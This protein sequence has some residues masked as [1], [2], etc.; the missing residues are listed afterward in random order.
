[1]LTADSVQTANDS[2]KVQ[3]LCNE[4]TIFNL[5]EPKLNLIDIPLHVPLCM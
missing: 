1:M 2:N 4:G 5:C 3:S